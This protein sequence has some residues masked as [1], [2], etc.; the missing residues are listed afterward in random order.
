MNGQAE[1]TI[2]ALLRHSTTTLVKGYAHLSPSHLKAA[3]EQ[4]ACFGKPS[5]TPPPS[6]PAQTDQGAIFNGT[7]TRTVTG[8]NGREGIAAE[9]VETIGAGEGI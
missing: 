2:A 9:V 5:Q 1:G 6:S 8:G 4:V 3:I 7:V